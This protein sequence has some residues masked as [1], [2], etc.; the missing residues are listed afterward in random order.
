MDAVEPK[1]KIDL[2]GAMDTSETSPGKRNRTM[3]N[4]V[5]NPGELRGIQ[6]KRRR[7]GDLH[8]AFVVN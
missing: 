3:A 6:A 7:V 5:K 4:A 1:R 8:L 2:A